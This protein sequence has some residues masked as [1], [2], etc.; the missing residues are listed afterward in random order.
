MALESKSFPMEPS[1]EETS[2]MVRKMEREHIA[3]IMEK[4]SMKENSEMET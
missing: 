2:L 1:I 3:G 4:W